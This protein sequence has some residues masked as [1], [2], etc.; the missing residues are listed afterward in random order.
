MFSGSEAVS[1]WAKPAVASAVRNGIVNGT[2]AGLMPASNITRA[3][4]AAIVQ[5]M[6][7]KVKLID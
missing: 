3:E 6:L 5:R 7:K 4:T 2:D 1:A